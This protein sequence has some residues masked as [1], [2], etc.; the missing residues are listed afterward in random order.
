MDKL[1]RRGF[2]MG[3]SAAIAG[4]AGARFN[5]AAFG[6]PASEPNQNILLTVFLRGGCDALSVITP[7]GGEDRAHYELARPDL[8]LPTNNLLPL[9]DQ[10]GLHQAAAPL[11]ELYQDGK[12]GIVL[13]AGMHEDTRSHFDAMTYMELGTPG[14]KGQ[15]SGWLTRL[16]Q[17][18]DIANTAVA[19]SVAL[20]RLQPTSQ[21]SHYETIS[22]TNPGNLNLDNGPWGWRTQQQETLRQIFSLDSQSNI[23][24][25]SLNALNTSITLTNQSLGNYTPHPSA[26]YPSGNF[27]DQLQVVA[28][29]IKSQL[30]LKVA[31]IDLGGWDTH[32]NQIQWGSPTTGYF[33]DLLQ[34]LAQ[35]LA[36][37]Y[38]DLDASSSNYTRRLTVVVM[39]EFGRRLKENAQRGTDHG[40]GSFMFALGGEVNGGLHG[41]WPGLHNDQLYDRADLAVTTDYRRVLSEIMIRRLGNN[42]VG[43]VFPNYQGYTPLGLVQGADLPPNYES[44][45][46]KLYLPLVTR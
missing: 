25:A 43:Q 41:Q 16:L 29:L 30:G 28:Q 20:G 7:L 18:T 23:H 35:G 3:C 38:T 9:N 11:H 21:L 17:T 27:G 13:A 45:L 19:P 1:T 6:D 36:A 32:E 8:T 14:Q 42:K 37:L 15:S 39:T 31:T 24:R 33:R 22:L 4:L 40:H 44:N 2:L 10:F 46:D 5:Y 26:N 34:R 12:L